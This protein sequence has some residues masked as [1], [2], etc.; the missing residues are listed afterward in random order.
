VL[1]GRLAP[2]DGKRAL[3]TN[4]SIDYYAQHQLE[5]LDARNTVLAEISRIADVATGP[6]LRGVLG[7]FRFSGDDVDKPVGVLSGGEKARLALAKMLLRPANLLLMD[8]PTNHLDIAS[9]EVLEE[10][11]R[12][13][14]GTLVVTSHDRRFIDAV[15]TKVL[16]VHPGARGVVSYPGNYSEY[17][18]KKAREGAAQAAAAPGGAAG[19]A[20]ADATPRQRDLERERKRREAEQRAKMSRVL[21]PLRERLA[22]VESA[23]EKGEA[24]QQQLTERLADPKLYLDAEASR[25]VAVEHDTV[26]RR[27]KELYA[28][29][30]EVQLQIDEAEAALAAAQADGEG[31]DGGDAAPSNGAGA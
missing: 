10:A 15:A 24:R 31:G 26:A 30:E 9:R 23:V 16:E 7:A 14:D 2:T 21:G 27:L 11:L 4:V 8:E 22:K 6:M 18:W 5:A 12:Q 28:H 20:S 29:W 1:A 25:A 13:Y 17:V 3:G 19:P